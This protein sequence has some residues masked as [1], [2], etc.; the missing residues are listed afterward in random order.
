MPAYHLLDDIVVP[1]MRETSQDRSITTQQREACQERKLR[2][3]FNGYWLCDAPIKNMRLVT[4]SVIKSYREKRIKVDGV[5]PLTVQGELALVSAAVNHAVREWD[6]N[7]INPFAKRLISKRDRQSIRPREWHELTV[8]EEKKLLLA[9]DSL[10][11]DIIEF[12]LHTGLRQREILQLQWDQIDGA[13]IT[14][15]PDQQKANRYSH[16]MMNSVALDVMKRR[17]ELA[18]SEYVFH[19]NGQ[20]IDRHK[21]S[22]WWNSARR[23]AGLPNLQF[24]DLRNNSGQRVL[25]ATGELTLAKYHLRHSE[26]RTT[27]KVY[28]K[29]PLEMMADAAESIVKL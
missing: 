21:F 25:E 28:V 4:G 20:L 26:I 18:V 1:Y 13:R 5:S 9:A 16:S 10:T 27:E 29:D 6:Y 2:E 11:R 23:I 22:K 7:L 8:A 24:R 3:Y 12:A 14:F 19:L 15:S 17:R